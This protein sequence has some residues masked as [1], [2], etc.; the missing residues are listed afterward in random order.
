MEV[1]GLLF[2]ITETKDKVVKGMRSVFELR[3]VEIEEG[4]DE[5]TRTESTSETPNPATTPRPQ[6]ARASASFTTSPEESSSSA[7]SSARSFSSSKVHL[8]EVPIHLQDAMQLDCLVKSMPGDGACLYYCG[9]DLVLGGWEH[10]ETLRKQGHRFIV[11]NWDYYRPFISLPFVETIGVGAA[12]RT[13]TKKTYGDMKKF[14]LS[15]ESIYCYSNS[16]LDLTNLA[17]MYDMKIAIFTYSSGGSVVP[18]WTWVHPDPAISAKSPYKNKLLF[19][20][21]WL[22]HEDN[23][24]YDLLVPR[25]I[26]S[27][28]KYSYV[29]TMSSSST[30]QEPSSLPSSTS[31]SWMSD[32]AFTL[33]EMTAEEVSETISE[34]RNSDITATTTR[35]ETTTIFIPMNVM[36][37]TRGVGRPIEEPLQKR[38]RKL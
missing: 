7:T 22:Y 5:N 19:R 38:Q 10:M 13:V 28:A 24:H 30:A 16:S 34:N 4:N 37:C 26:P 25:P 14:L 18:H 21:M 31:C 35:A 1:A 9:A 27:P 6:S 20:E 3:K 23:S 11:E 15:N 32:A 8:E 33:N 29:P 2:L 36:Q 17:N 12:K